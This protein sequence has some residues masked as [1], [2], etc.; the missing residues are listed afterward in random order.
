MLLQQLCL[1]VLVWQCQHMIGIVVVVVLVLRVLF[2]IVDNVVNV[3]IAVV[4]GPCWR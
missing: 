2:F 1:Y 4:A 3:G